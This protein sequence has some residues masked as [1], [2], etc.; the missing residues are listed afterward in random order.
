MNVSTKIDRIKIPSGMEKIF[1][2]VTS[3]LGGLNLAAAYLSGSES[4][5]MRF[6]GMSMILF[7]ASGFLLGFIRSRFLMAEIK[8]EGI[9]FT[10]RNKFKYLLSSK[11]ILRIEIRKARRRHTVALVKDDGG[12]VDLKVFYIRKNA[13]KFREALM[14]EFDGNA[15]ILPGDEFSRDVFVKIEND[16]SIFSWRDSY[17]GVYGFSLALLFSGIVLMTGGI[18]AADLKRGTH[19]LMIFVMIPWIIFMQI[20]WKKRNERPAILLGKDAFAFGKEIAGNFF[21]IKD[22]DR[23]NIKSFLYSY[24]LT[25]PVQNLMALYNNDDATRISLPGLSAADSLSMS[26]KFKEILNQE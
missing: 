3:M 19:I 1:M 5:I 26:K 11:D 10:A 15:E 20:R 23:K 22:L 25:T 9:L 8:G 13:Q 12:F 6:V 14:L 7:S 4:L 21:S 17:S 2:T 16:R 18:F 24:D